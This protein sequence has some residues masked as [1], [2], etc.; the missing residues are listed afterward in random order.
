[1]INLKWISASLDNSGYASCSRKY[2]TGLLNSRK[3]NLTLTNISFETITS[4]HQTYFKKIEPYLNKNLDTKIQ[5]IHLT[6]DNYI[7]YDLSKHYTIGYTTWETDKLPPKW[8]DYINLCDEVWVPSSWNKECFIKN[9]VNKPI[10]IIPHIVN[11]SNLENINLINIGVNSSS[12]LFYSIFQWIERKNPLN[13]LKAYLT[14][15]NPEDNVA[16]LLKTYRV[17]SSLKEQEIIKNQIAAFKQSLQ[18]SYYPPIIFFGDIMTSDDIKALHKT[19]DCYVSFHRGEGFGLTIA[20][21]MGYAKPVIATNY[22]GNTDYMNKEN[23]FLIDYQLS[24][25][26]GMIFPN[27]DGKQ[28]WA[29]PNV[30]DLKNQM[31]YCYENKQIANEKGKRAQE[32]VQQ[33]LNEEKIIN[34]IINRLNE[35]NKTIG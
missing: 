25:V 27:Y 4:N 2:I 5:V 29:E 18:L 15:F 6:P 8:V 34:L 28:I 9:G 13:L 24:P 17:N 20:E 7:Q 21:A 11:T 3:I 19:G 26:F 23:S 1:M 32:F 33:T 31:R 16:L 30:V 12:Y 22:S 14:E 35:I 10:Y